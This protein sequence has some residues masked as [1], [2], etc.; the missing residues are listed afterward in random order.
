MGLCSTP[1]EKKPTNYVDMT[2]SFTLKSA[3]N[4]QNTKN[5]QNL[6]NQNVP[7]NE[8]VPNNENNLQLELTL[9]NCSSGS[10]YYIIV[11]FLNT[12]DSFQTETV[13]CH[14]NIIT[15]NKTY[16]CTYS[17]EI[18]Q[19][20]RITV[21]KNGQNIG[22]FTPYLG[23]IVGSPNST[24]RVKVSPDK[25][26]FIVISAKSIGDCKNL[27]IFNFMIKANKNVN[28]DDTKNKIYFMIT[29]NYKKIYSSEL[30][31]KYG[32][33]KTTSIPKE[34]LEPQFEVTFFNYRKEKI[35]SKLET[36]DSFT[37]QNNQVYLTLNVN[38]NDYYI[39]NNSQLSQQYSF[40]DYIKNGVQIALSIGI[41]FTR[42][43]GVLND[44][45]SL[46]RIIPGNFNDYEQAI[47]SCGLI[48]AFYDY[49]QLFP[50]YGFGAI[51]DNTNQVNNCFNIN[52]QQNPEIHTIDNVIEEYHKC[53]R[54]IN[55]WGPTYF[56][57]IIKK[58]IELIN[59][60]NNPLI[61]HVLMIL[62]D[63]V[64]DDFKE[65]I[66]A[67]IEAS[68]LPFSLIIIGIGNADFTNMVILDGDNVPL[69]SSNGVKRLRDV[70]QFVPFN[71]Y[72]NNNEELT[73]QVLEEIPRQITEFYS[74]LKIY[75]NN[76]KNQTLR[77]TA[78]KNMNTIMYN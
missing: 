32:Q 66:D 43:N 47:S 37:G 18:P 76:L 41:D 39:Y 55:L 27:L 64:I 16:L 52:F 20:M 73:K 67:I 1:E 33:F 7:Y 35:V 74:M 30:I 6:P 42:S 63:G 46:H 17:F 25:P 4:I 12:S 62:T 61:Y 51:I 2:R 28:F 49:D 3:Q 22:S 53:L 31:S 60:E 70:V 8:N 10:R 45:N 65:T 14:G 40:I 78:L 57:P 72:R 68:F 77:A 48:M 36:P 19:L 26:E 15:F 69:I 44:P 9:D 58:E 71:K 59:R 38:N 21:F 75:P 5:I 56:S 54:K 50:V 34:L 13:T 11:E 24:F 23:S 29:S